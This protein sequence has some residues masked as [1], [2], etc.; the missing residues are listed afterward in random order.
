M[1]SAPHVVLLTIDCWRYDRCGFNGYSRPTTPALDEL[2]GESFVFDRAFA[3]G[4][5]T[6]G[7]FPGIL[8]GHHSY[9]GSVNSRHPRSEVQGIPPGS[10]TLASH[11]RTNGYRTVATVTNAHLLPSLN[12]DAGFDEFD[13]VE[14]GDRDD[15]GGDESSVGDDREREGETDS[16]SRGP[17]MGDVFQELRRR[18]RWEQGSASLLRNPYALPFVAYRFNQLQNWPSPP[19]ASVI[20]A[21][22]QQLDDAFESGTPVFGWTHLMDLHAPIHPAQVNEGGLVSTARFEAFRCDVERLC[23]V[24]SPGYNAMYDSVV[25]YIDGQIAALVAHLKERGVWENTVLVV[26]GDHGE[27]L[28]DRGFYGHPAHYMYDELLHVPLLVRAPMGIGRRLD[29]PFSLGWLHELV[30]DVAG[31]PRGQF[32]A[33]SGRT[34]HVTDEGDEDAVVVS[35]ALDDLGHSIVTRNGAWKYWRVCDARKEWVYIDLDEENPTTWDW[36]EEGTAFRVDSDRT[37]RHPLPGGVAPEALSRLADDLETTNADRPKL[38]V[39]Y[40]SDVEDRL[41][42]L[43]YQM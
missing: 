23:N 3:T 20:D 12:F 43:G 11:F 2:A 1:N 29:G 33:E 40:D 17:T 31:V 10:E 19:A 32:P 7:S 15:E 25:R 38:R 4:S 5:V 16:G 9:D 24:Y 34:S 35:D 26:T 41:K 8:A 14:V 22:T 13:N 6:A 21:F 39:E 27:A 36:T 37:E 42:Q 18:L 30:S 28:G